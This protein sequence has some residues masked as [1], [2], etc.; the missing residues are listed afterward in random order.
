MPRPLCQDHDRT[1]GARQV[2][3]SNSVSKETISDHDLINLPEGQ[4]SPRPFVGIM[5]KPTGRAIGGPSGKQRSLLI[6]LTSHL[7]GDE[8]IGKK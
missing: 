4:A 5:V 8:T 3:P 6:P 7:F 2:G 1:N